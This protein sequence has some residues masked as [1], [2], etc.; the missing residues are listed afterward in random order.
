MTGS[1]Q[2][3]PRQYL[4][5]GLGLRSIYYQEI[6]NT[7]PPIDW[8]E[9]ISED[10][11][12]EGG[13]RLFYLDKIRE[14]YPVVMHGVSLSIGG[15]DPLNKEYL[16]KLKQLMQRIDP[17]WVSDHLC[18]TGVEGKN[19]H[20]LMPLPYTEEAL[21]NVVQRINQVQDFLG[22]QIILE[23][24]SSYV[25]YQHSVMQEWEFMTAIAELA[26]C[27]LLV[28]INNIYVSSYNHKFDPHTFIQ[29]IP[30]HRVQQFHLAGHSNEGDYIVDTHDEPVIEEV[31]QLYATALK[32]FGR[33]STLIERDANF[34]PF[35]DL[36]KEVCRARET[37]NHVA[38]A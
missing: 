34:P 36:L 19:F 27:R 38:T 21:K 4:G 3:I 32:H 10:Y 25:T 18:W 23:N 14:E 8:F 12:V 28:D 11:L 15:T 35:D 6:L 13:N 1:Y 7:L 20:D 33:V 37:M 24:V 9:I 17:V 30:K 22:Q 16:S 26:D 31:W 5:C 29:S 2:K